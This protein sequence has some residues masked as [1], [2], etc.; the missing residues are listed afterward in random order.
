MF[1]RAYGRTL[2]SLATNASS[3]RLKHLCR[4]LVYFVWR[5]TPEIRLESDRSYWRVWTYC[6]VTFHRLRHRYSHFKF[7]ISS[8]PAELKSFWPE[9]SRL[10][11]VSNLYHVN[12]HFSVGFTTGKCERD[13][14]GAFFT[15]RRGCVKISRKWGW[16]AK[17]SRR[18]LILSRFLLRDGLLWG[19]SGLTRLYSNLGP[20][21]DAVHER[22]AAFRSV[23]WNQIDR[24]CEIFCQSASSIISSLDHQLLSSAAMSHS[25]L[26][27]SNIDDP[28]GRASS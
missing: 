7:Q 11:V 19:Q 4:L 26:T 13:H 14:N 16:S 20:L 15:P 25:G 10:E 2:Q 12:C 24:Q 18:A 1:A 28:A 9:I 21:L 6:N 27:T 17:S 22:V 8:H 3:T 5:C 23:L